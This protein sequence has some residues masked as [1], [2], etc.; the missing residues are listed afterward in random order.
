MTKD[1]SRVLEDAL[2]LAPAERALIADELLATLDDDSREEIEAVWAA[3]IER[4]VADARANPDDDVDWREA[5]QEIE[6]DVP[7]R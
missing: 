6:Q 3:E 2:H 1:A 7:G 4:R 5:L